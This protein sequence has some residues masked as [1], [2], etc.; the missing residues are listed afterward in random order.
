MLPIFARE[1]Y[2]QMILILISNEIVI[3]DRSL[4]TEIKSLR[5]NVNDFELGALIGRGQFGEVRVVK[6]LQTN[7]IYAMKILRKTETA[8]SENVR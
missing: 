5:V 8:A 1:A 6:E 4:V 7:D 2:N 3:A